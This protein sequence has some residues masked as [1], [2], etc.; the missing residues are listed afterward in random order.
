MQ[1]KYF[2]FDIDGT[3]T[4]RETNQIV[5]SAQKALEELQ[6]AGHFVAIATGRAHYKA[7]DFMRET[8]LTNM[9]CAGGGGLVLAEELVKNQPLDLKTALALLQ[10]A[11]DLGVG[12]LIMLDDSAK[13][14]SKNDLF[15]QQVGPRKEATEYFI[16]ETLDYEKLPEIYKIWVSI[17]KEQEE[18]LTLKNQLGY[19]RF[20]PEYLTIQYDDKYQGIIDMMAHLQADTKDVVVFGDDTND[21]VMFTP[22][23]TSIAMGNAHPDL[24]AKADYV[25]EKNIEDGIYRACQKFGWI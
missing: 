7:I 25:T 19:V 23:W 17:S 12:T 13:V 6:A 24:K 2:F 1:K 9:V 4:D 21:L 15:R 3:L 18:L 5:P 8:G 14:Y 20:M 10:Q 16:D 22:E 11:E